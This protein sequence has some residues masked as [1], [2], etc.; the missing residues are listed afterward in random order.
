MVGAPYGL[1]AMQ[2]ETHYE[3]DGDAQVSE[4][5]EFLLERYN[6][7]GWSLDHGEDKP[8]FEAKRIGGYDHTGDLRIEGIE[9]FEAED[10]DE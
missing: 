10:D 8:P 7:T 6:E 4:V 9:T 1:L 3:F 2:I 5:T